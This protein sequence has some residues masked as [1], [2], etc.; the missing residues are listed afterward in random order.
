MFCNIFV[1]VRF[2]R[3]LMFIDASFFK[4]FYEY[5]DYESQLIAIVKYQKTHLEWT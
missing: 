1:I 4:S 5:L 3:Q 2:G